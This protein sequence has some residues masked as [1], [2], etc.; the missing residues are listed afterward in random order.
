MSVPSAIPA[1]PPL[2]GLQNPALGTRFHNGMDGR[3]LLGTIFRVCKELRVSDIQMR[4][5]RPVYIHTNK[6]MEKLDFLG[7]LSALN[8]DEILKELIRNRESGSHGFGEHEDLGDR[9][10]DKIEDAMKNFAETKVADFSCDGIPMGDNGERSG[11]LRIQAHLSSSGL[12][13][14]CRILND[15]I[16]ELESLG[17]DPDTTET[18]R[19]GVLKR[20]G[21]C[22][23]TGPTGSGKSTTLASLIDWLRRNHPKHI[24][25]VEDPIEYQYP[26]D[27]PDPEYAGHRMPSPS[28]VTQQEVGRDVH[29]YR[30]G[31]K[32]VLRKAPHVI[33]LGEIRDRE[34]METC[35]E[36]AQTGHLVLSTLHTTGAVKTLGRIL[37]M[38]PRE[39]HNAVLS[40]LSEILIFIHSQGLLN[41]VQ[42]RVLTY[43]FLQNNDDAVASAIANYD[44]G[45]RSLEDVIRRAGNIEWD[46]NLRRLRRQ[47][48]ITD[49]TY[50]SARMNR[51]EAEIL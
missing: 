37:E 26:D 1:P 35:M 43:E 24:V 42:R 9:V 3:F 51:S 6:G 32:D 11:R 29:S 27:M 19:Q 40:R 28:I 44:G 17:I 38:Y 45:A 13:V 48:L 4:A 49:A 31:L 16:P 7:I 47:G 15:F 5:E 36:A 20:A 30:Q 21:L 25:T 22:L 50:E 33:L 2:P 8:M 34:A 39:S 12:G 10:G 41:G 18:L 14:T 46:G 23:V